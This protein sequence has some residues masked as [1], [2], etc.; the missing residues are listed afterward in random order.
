MEIKKVSIDT[1][2]FDKNN[3]RKHGDFN[4]KTIE[5]S[6]KRFGQVEPLVVQIKD[7]TVIGGN[8]R[9]EVMKKLGYN[10][11]DVVFVDLNDTEATALSLVLNRS[12]EL[13]EWDKDILGQQLISLE[14]LEF[15]LESIGF[16]ADYGDPEFE[17]KDPGDKDDE[18]KPDEI[19]LTVFFE[20]MEDQRAVFDELK[21]RG[22]KVK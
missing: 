4:L 21:N 14:D 19:K 6:L 12:S 17:F 2:N 13:A 5:N 3:A 22:Y 15:D 1:L 16:D 11:V 10:E 7:N 18:T 9:L 8:G 20:S